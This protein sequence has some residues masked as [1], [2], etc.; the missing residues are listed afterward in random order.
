MSQYIFCDI[1]GS[2]FDSNFLECKKCEHFKEGFNK[3]GR[4]KPNEEYQLEMIIN[5]LE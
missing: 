4:T 1:C 2:S 5:E 3:F